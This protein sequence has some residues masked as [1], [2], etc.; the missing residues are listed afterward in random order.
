VRED[1]RVFQDPASPLHRWSEF[2]IIIGTAAA[3]LTGLM[4]VVI[5]LVAGVRRTVARQGIATF[6]T[7]TVVQFSF[8]L[9]IAAVLAAPWPTL[10][11][12]AG[13]L[14]VAS[15]GALAY[16][17][18]IF[19]QTGRRTAQD[20]E[21]DLE[22]RLFYSWLPLVAYVALLASAVLLPFRTH[23]AL[24]VLAGTTMAL[25]FIGIHNAWDVITFV[26]RLQ[27]PGESDDDG[28]NAVSAE[29]SGT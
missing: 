23:T 28:T 8:A 7:P 22:D 21:P 4:F 16:A 20:Y 26:T 14:A 19:M 29:S 5:T 11:C 1:A 27:M 10:S 9:G 3:S 2:Y 15:L 24:F 25:I 18:A 6:S 17:T 13:L 12:V